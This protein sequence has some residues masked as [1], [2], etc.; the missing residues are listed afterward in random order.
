MSEQPAGVTVRLY[1]MLR[2]FRPQDA[3]GAPHH[4]FFVPL[5]APPTLAALAAALG[6]PEG[7]VAGAARNG[8]A[9]ALTAPLAAGDDVRFFPP[10][11][12]G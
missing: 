4:P 2:E 8:E 5:P 7:L 3:G 11:S 10:V 6:L 12:G 1:G 9:V